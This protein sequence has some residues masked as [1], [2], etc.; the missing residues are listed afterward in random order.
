MLHCLL[1]EPSYHLVFRVSKVKMWSVLKAFK[2]AP[3][4]HLTFHCNEN[5]NI[6]V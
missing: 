6:Q 3:Y 1:G 2:F 4:F 5:F